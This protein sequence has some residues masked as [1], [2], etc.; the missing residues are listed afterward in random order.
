[1]LDNVV[2]CRA[3]QRGDI[4][5]DLVNKGGPMKEV[6]L[7][8]AL[9]SA[10]VALAGAANADGGS[11]SLAGSTDA[12]ILGSTGIPTP[13]AAYIAG[14]ES[15][16]LDPNG[17]AGTTASTLA[18]TTP[19]TY[20]LTSSVTQGEQDL[21]NAVVADYDA[22]NMDCTAVGVCN[23]PLTIFTYSQSSAI[24]AL[25]EQQL[26]ADNIPTD[27]LRFVM[28]GAD[29]IGVPDNLYP[30][31]VYNIDGD[32]WVL[33]GTLGTTWQ[34]IELELVLHF[35]YLWLSPAEIDA[36]TPVV[37]GMTTLYDIPTLTTTQLIDAL[38]T[39]FSTGGI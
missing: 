22:G 12:L 32:F 17:Y 36:A 26:A 1:M 6:I 21:V 28:T 11:D 29:P 10:A 15:L 20:D 27:A 8:V 2:A 13:D 24:A 4:I 31:D 9:C 3:D 19:E 5:C 33:P 34:D 23:D 39:A 35:A 25:A 30:T 14:A 18:L 38:L 37:D 7:G 16:Y